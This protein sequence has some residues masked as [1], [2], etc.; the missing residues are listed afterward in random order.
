MT[1]NYTGIAFIEMGLEPD[2]RFER[3]ARERAE[4]QGWTFEK[5]AGDLGLLRAL[6]GGPPWDNDRF[7]VVPPGHRVATAFDETIIKAER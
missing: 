1:R 3:Q 7:L 5:L 4:E 2:D 6:V